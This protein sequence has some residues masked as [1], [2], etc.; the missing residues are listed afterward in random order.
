LPGGTLCRPAT[1]RARGYGIDG[2][3]V[4][5]YPVFVMSGRD[6]ERRK[7]ME[8]LDP[9]GKYAVKNLLPFLGKRVIDWQLEALRASPYV[10]DIYLIGLSPEEATFDLP[11][12]YVPSDVTTDFADKLFAGLAYL[13]SLGKEPSQ[14]IISSSDA[15]GVA[16]EQVNEFLEAL[17]GL[18]DYDFVLS[19]VPEHV[20]EAEFPASGRVVARFRDHQVFP[21]ELYALSEEAI[22][23]GHSIIRDLNRRRRLIN[24][25]KGRIGLGPVI[26]PLARKPST[27]P[28]ILKFLLKRATLRDGERLLER[29]LG[30]RVRGVIIAD[31]GFGMD[32]DLPE[33]Y[34]RLEGAPVDPVVQTGPAAGRDAGGDRQ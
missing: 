22:E 16:T 15:P 19:L 18:E 21:G 9:G 14:V 3:F 1:G 10:E 20:A 25:E 6:R 12:H 26:T 27:W 32:M 29:A 13:K 23:V 33:D 8:V 30:C 5:K 34:A 31:P 11:V 28:L 4:R 17:S 2:G 24:R 7:I